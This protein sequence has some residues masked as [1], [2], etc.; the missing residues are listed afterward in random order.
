MDESTVQY[1][2]LEMQNSKGY[3]LCDSIYILEKERHRDR[4]IS[5][6]TKD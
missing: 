2:Q 1:M 4:N 5:M 3:M 6:V